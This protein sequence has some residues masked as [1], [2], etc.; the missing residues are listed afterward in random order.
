[1]KIGEIIE[2]AYLKVKGG[3]PDAGDV[4]VKRIELRA[5]LPA[6]V[7][8]AL[9]K[10]YY[11]DKLEGEVSYPNSFVATYENVEVKKNTNRDLYYIDLPKG[12]VPLPRDV[13]VDLVGPMKGDDDFVRITHQYQD[14]G[15]S[16]FISK[17]RYFIE[18]DK[19]Y[20]KNLSPSTC[21][22]LLRM[23]AS[24]DAFDDDAEAPI[25]A[26]LE[27]EVIQIMFECFYGQRKVV[28]DNIV[29]HSDEK[30]V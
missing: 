17:T 18:G 16:Q 27:V 14:K 7:N 25:P 2:L 8:F 1:M 24:I 9:R 28:E 11:I 19:V 6:A 22:I 12:V 4:N 23:L 26:G 3:R 20:F 29:N 5:Y 10:Q 30:Q 15:Y 13:G 21:K